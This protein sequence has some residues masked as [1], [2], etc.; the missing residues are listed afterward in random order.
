M[1]LY[2]F[3]IN[4]EREKQLGV[5]TLPCLAVEVNVNIYYI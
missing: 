1:Q 5:S 4:Y 3:I 2:L